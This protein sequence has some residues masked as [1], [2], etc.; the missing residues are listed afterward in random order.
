MNA[1]LP[2]IETATK[3]GNEPFHA[4]RNN[5]PQTLL[6]YW[7]W[8]GSDLVSNAQRG[9][10]G[11]FLV[12]SARLKNYFD[13]FWPRDCI[14]QRLL[15][16]FELFVAEDIFY[17]QRRQVFATTGSGGEAILAP[18]SIRRLG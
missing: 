13:T 14:P 17:L 18:S 1:E 3:M 6:D 10:L 8:A 2:R 12:G 5:L 16:R 9:I 7:R 11:E 15:D 4:D